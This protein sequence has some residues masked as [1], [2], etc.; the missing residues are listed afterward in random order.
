[1]AP[2]T[3][4]VRCL[5]GLW[6]QRSWGNKWNCFTAI[7]QNEGLN[8]VRNDSSADS[9]H[10]KHDSPEESL[11]TSSKPRTMAKGWG[12]TKLSYLRHL[13]DGLGKYTGPLGHP[14]RP[15]S[16]WPGRV[17]ITPLVR[18]RTKIG[19]NGRRHVEKIIQSN[20]QVDW[21]NPCFRDQRLYIFFFF[22]SLKKIG[23]LP[24]LPCKR[25]R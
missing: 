23:W 20:F 12:R 15:R 4:Q 5:S 6:W 9:T 17:T 7:N 14:A 25:E 2:V 16:Q 24:I 13:M 18:E 8:E 19:T 11:R 10:F 1:M 22:W 21:H 3:T